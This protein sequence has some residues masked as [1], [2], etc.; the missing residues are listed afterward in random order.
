M[1]YQLLKRLHNYLQAPGAG[2]FDRTRGSRHHADETSHLGL[3]HR[4]RA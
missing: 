2:I 1:V 3:V 4:Q